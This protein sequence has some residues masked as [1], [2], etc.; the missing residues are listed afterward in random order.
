MYDMGESL[1][2][3][4]LMGAG[5]RVAGADRGDKGVAGRRPADLIVVAVDLDGAA[6]THV[7][8]HPVVVAGD[9]KGAAGS[10]DRHRVA[11]AGEAGVLAVAVADEPG[12]AAGEIDRRIGRQGSLVSGAER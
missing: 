8:E 11:A 5:H 1:L 9:L 10:A 4:R 7:D 6:R 12:V 2:R 3:L